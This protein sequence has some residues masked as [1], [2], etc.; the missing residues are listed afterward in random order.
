MGWK[1][2]TGGAVAVLGWL[3]Q[4]DVLAFLPEKVGA[5]VTAAGALLGVFGIRHAIAKHGAR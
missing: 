5:I 1:T 4:P 3:S 2:I